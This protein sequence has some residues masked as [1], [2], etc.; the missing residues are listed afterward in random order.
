MFPE[1]NTLIYFCF[2]VHE[3]Q[4]KTPAQQRQEHKTNQD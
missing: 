1:K 3:E 4:Y 2:H